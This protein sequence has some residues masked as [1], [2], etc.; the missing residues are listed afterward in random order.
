M[1]YRNPALTHHCACSGIRC[2]AASGLPHHLAGM[3][4]GSRVRLGC[5]DDKG[6]LVVKVPLV[7]EGPL[8][9]CINT[10]QQ[11]YLMFPG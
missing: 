7:E 1:G 5:K 3:R 4:R 6:A 11:H 10:Q 8:A 2:C 9:Y